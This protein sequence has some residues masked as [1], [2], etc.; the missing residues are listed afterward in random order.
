MTIHVTGHA[1]ARYQERVANLPDEQVIATLTGPAFEAAAA[2][3]APY[4]KLANAAHVVIA[5]GSVVTVLPSE[6]HP[7][8]LINGGRE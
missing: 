4:V 2:F 7:L 1:I 5:N 3:G 8:R 6:T